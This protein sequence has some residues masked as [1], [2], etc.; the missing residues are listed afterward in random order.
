MNILTALVIALFVGLAVVVALTLIVAPDAVRRSENC[1][2]YG[3]K[4]HRNG[5][6][7]KH[8]PRRQSPR[9]YPC[10]VEY[11]RERTAEQGDDHY[12]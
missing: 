12:D 1:T 6:N 9:D 7:P 10:R 8:F 3:A 5:R 4:R 11:V 2:V